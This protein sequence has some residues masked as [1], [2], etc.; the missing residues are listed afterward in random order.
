MFQC[1]PKGTIENNILREIKR[2]G[3]T[4]REVSRRTGISDKKMYSAFEGRSELRL[5]YFLKICQLLRLDPREMAGRQSDR[6][7]GA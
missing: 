7:G 1:Q 6:K 2:N 4:V 3:L 5:G